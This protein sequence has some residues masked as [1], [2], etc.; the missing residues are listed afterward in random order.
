MIRVVVIAVLLVLAAVGGWW[1]F[2]TDQVRRLEREL[3]LL[4]QEMTARL[5]ERDAMIERLSRSRRVGR[6][7]I[8]DQSRGPNGSIVETRVRFVELDD[9][10]REIGR[11]EATVPGSVLFLDAL[12][13][14]FDPE[15]VAEGHPM[16]GR[17][18]VLLRRLYSEQLRPMDGVPIDTPGGVPAGYAGSEEARYEQAV[19]RR[20][21]EIAADSELARSMGVRVAQGEAVYR[22][23]RAGEAYD[24]EVEAVGGLSLVAAED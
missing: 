18:L 14:K 13:V 19:W 1:W 23:V 8:L 10:G 21:W 5:A 7:E 24:L 3:L 9:G 20:F 11:M 6:L 4:E 16:M 22:P 12:V 15:R 2:T 17:S